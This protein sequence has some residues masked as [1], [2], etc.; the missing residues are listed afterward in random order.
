[1]ARNPTLSTNPVG[2]DGIAV[3]HTPPGG[4]GETMPPPVLANRT[5]PIPSGA[6]DLRGLWQVVTVEADGVPDPA[7]RAS[8]LVMCWP[9][10][11]PRRRSAALPSMR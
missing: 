6:P 7:H 5:E 2:V 8:L 11:R 1:M 3:A 10:E 9:T 4:Y